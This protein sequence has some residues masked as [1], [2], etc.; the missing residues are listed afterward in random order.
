MNRI[1]GNK[2]VPYL[3]RSKDDLGSRQNPYLL[4]ITKGGKKIPRFFILK[5]IKNIFNIVKRRLL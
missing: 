3:E 5:K 4:Y 2:V 1:I